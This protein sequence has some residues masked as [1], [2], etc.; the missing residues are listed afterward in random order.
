[1]LREETDASVILLNP[2]GDKLARAQ[3]VSGAY[4]AGL[5][6]LPKQ[7]KWKRALIDELAQFPNAPNDDQADSSS[8]GV[9]YMRR[10]SG[11]IAHAA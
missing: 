11:D 10:F 1:M 4:E 7:A 2:E 5:V 6:R 9:K 8:Q 3:G